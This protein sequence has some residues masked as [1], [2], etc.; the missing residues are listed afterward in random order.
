MTRGSR[1]RNGRKTGSRSALIAGGTPALPAP[2]SRHRGV[3]ELSAKNHEDVSVRQ[4]AS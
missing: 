3:D 2:S 4:L 1:A